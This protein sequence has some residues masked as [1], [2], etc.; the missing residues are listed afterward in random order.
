M[1]VA[2]DFQRLELMIQRLGELSSEGRSELVKALAATALHEVVNGFRHERDPYGAPWKPLAERNGRIL[3]DRG[4]LAASFATQI[5]G[6]G[7]RVS[8]NVAYAAPHQ[9]GAI[10]K[11]R[12][13]VNVRAKN[14]RFRKRATLRN[15]RKAVRVSITHAHSWRLPQRMMVPIASR[16]LG[17]IWGPAFQQTVSRIMRRLLRS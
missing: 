17:P 6:D 16:G 15:V 7:F 13:R 9:D 2:A 8:S 14:G 10:I 5:Q 12:P 3:R 4:R 11:V 1:G